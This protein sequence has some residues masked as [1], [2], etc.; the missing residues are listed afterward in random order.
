VVATFMAGLALGSFLGGRLADRVGLTV[1]WYACVEIA[2]AGLGA[3][4]VDALDWVQTTYVALQPRD[5]DQAVGEIV[6]LRFVLAAAVILIPTTLMGATLPLMVRSSLSLAGRVGARV[7]LLYAG[8]T[9]GAI[10]GCL[11][12]GFVLIGGLGLRESISAAAVLNG[13][14]GLF[15]LILGI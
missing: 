11:L 7:S 9:S 13:I 6:L 3:K 5:A 1:L 14:A 12:A 10:L 4:S 2:I 8:N 15:A